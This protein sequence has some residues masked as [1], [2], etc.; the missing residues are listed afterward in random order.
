VGRGSGTALRSQSYAPVLK[1][2]GDRDSDTTRRGTPLP[3][4]GRVLIGASGPYRRKSFAGRPD[5]VS[6][7]RL[8]R[9]G[10]FQQPRLIASTISILIVQSQARTDLPDVDFP[11]LVGGSKL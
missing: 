10:V 11:Q 8:S 9:A 1:V 7:W 4:P 2:I 3:G 6:F 5:A